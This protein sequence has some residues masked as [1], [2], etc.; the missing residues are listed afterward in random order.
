MRDGR[1]VD[2]AHDLADRVL[3]A[4]PRLGAARLV[5]IDGPS[6]AGK[7]HLAARVVDVLRGRGA[8][9]A[10]VSTDDFATWDDPVSW[11]PRLTAGV[12]RP[13]EAGRPGRYRRTEW[14]DA[15]DPVPGAQVDVPVPG[16]LVL[17]GVSS[18]RRSVRDSTS[19]LCWLDHADR[20]ARLERALARD[21]EWSRPHLERWQRFETGWFAVDEPWNAADVRYSSEWSSHLGGSA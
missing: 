5:V 14:T 9:P 7:S 17:E 8:D 18:G 6:G 13:V 16:V 15:G 3:A 4:P 19:V 10:L 12:L 1:A 2:P 21:G 20:T 11:W